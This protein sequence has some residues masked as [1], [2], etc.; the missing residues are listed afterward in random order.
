MGVV[1]EGR[2][3]NINRRVAIKTARRD[4]M[5]STGMA[6]EMMVRFLRE[7]QAAGALNHP[8]IITIYDAGEEGGVAYI[9]MEFLEGGNLRDLLD[10][11]RRLSCEEIVEIGADLCDALA[12]AHDAGIVHRDIKPAN[13]MTPKNGQVKIADFGIARV[14]D[15]NLTQEGALIG[16]PHYMSPEQ[17]MGQKLDGRS[18]LFSVGNILYEMITGEKPFTG[19][20]LSTVM[21]HVIKTDPVPPSEF[22]LTMPDTLSQVVMKSLSKRPAQRYATGRDM[23][24]ALRESLKPHPNPAIIEGKTGDATETIIGAGVVDAG[25]TVVTTGAGSGA[26][27]AT[28]SGSPDATSRVA[29]NS[30]SMDAT[31]PAAHPSAMPN[32]AADAAARDPRVKL[33][34]F[35]GV[36]AAVVLLLGILIFALG[37]TKDE[38]AAPGNGGTATLDPTKRITMDIYIAD[39]E[40]TFFD[41]S[42]EEGSP[43]EVKRKKFQELL[44]ARKIRPAESGSVTVTNKGAEGTATGVI[45]DGQASIDIVGSPTSVSIVAEVPG[46]PAAKAELPRG[47]DGTWDAPSIVVSP[48]D[49]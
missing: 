18:D 25:A 40:D 37:G 43:Q 45:K 42:L 35:G 12:A 19:E 5:E 14:S 38:G 6:E 26:A 27:G 47:A 44:D 32:A 30:P 39:S 15:S 13:I 10:A 21:H 1:Y 48:K 16:T 3:P 22:N 28:S 20:A 17:F 24:A 41:W 34:A 36:G 49:S 4:V 31:A 29:A 33:M 46:Y 8:N 11:R 9:A 23:A 2:D 7:A